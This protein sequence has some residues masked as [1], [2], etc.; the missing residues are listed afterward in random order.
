M[1]LY[2]PSNHVHQP[3]TGEDGRDLSGIDERWI[4]FAAPLLLPEVN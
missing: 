1:R 4:R 2:D 3:L